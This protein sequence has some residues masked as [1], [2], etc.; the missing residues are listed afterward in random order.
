MV[1][2]REVIDEYLLEHNIGPG[3]SI[4]REEIVRWC[5]E[6]QER[7]E[8]NCTEN[9]YKQQI[10]KMIIGSQK[11]LKERHSEGWD[12]VFCQSSQGK[13]YVVTRKDRI[14]PW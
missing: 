4:D 5:L 12:D 13:P 10:G 6:N 9:T 11:N 3:T 14:C 2:A 8:V 7:F 1:G